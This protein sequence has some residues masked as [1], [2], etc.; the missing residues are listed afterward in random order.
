[1]G[2]VWQTTD[3]ATTAPTLHPSTGAIRGADRPH[4]GNCLWA[5]LMRRSLGVD[6]LALAAV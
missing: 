2:L 3:S 1:M 5:E 4:A 6:A